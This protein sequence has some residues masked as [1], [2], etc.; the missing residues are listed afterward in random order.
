[1]RTV[2]NVL[3]TGILGI[4]IAGSAGMALASEPAVHTMAVQ[5]PY[6]ETIQIRYTGDV[7]PKVL[8]S[9]NAFATEIADPTSSFVTLDRISAE[10]DWV[11][12]LMRQVDLLA[13]PFPNSVPIVEGEFRGG[14]PGF[15]EYS[16]VSTVSVNG[17]TCTRVTEVTGMK[18][19]QRPKLISHTSGNC[20]SAG[21]PDTGGPSSI[22][23]D[24]STPRTVP[25]NA[26]RD[27]SSSTVPLEYAVY[28]PG[29]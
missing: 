6:G 16:L 20:A 14:A 13:I 28:Q 17:N 5:L 26:R 24:R 11:N 10:M 1:M 22:S 7:A 25:I 12:A 21:H 27:S 4:A 19:G 15:A 18:N 9:P 29:S 23:H 2:R 3:T 8:L